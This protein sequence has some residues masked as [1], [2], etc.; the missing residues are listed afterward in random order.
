MGSLSW[1]DGRRAVSPMWRSGATNWDPLPPAW[2]PCRASGQVPGLVAK[3][4]FAW[5]IRAVAGGICNKA[6]S[7]RENTNCCKNS[8]RRRGGD[9]QN[10]NRCVMSSDRAAAP[11][12]FQH[13]EHEESTE[14]HGERQYCASREA[15]EIAGRR[16]WADQVA[17]PG[18]LRG[19]P[20]VLRVLRVESGDKRAPV[21]SHCDSLGRKRGAAARHGG[22]GSVLT[23]DNGN[24]CTTASTQRH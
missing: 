24:G 15:P 19:T 12:D 13:G 8:T 23:L 9:R 18:N 17:A 16:Q 10:R 14:F 6:A 7:G 2:C 5:R 3:A 22:D 20:C 11:A 21:P 4:R 1:D